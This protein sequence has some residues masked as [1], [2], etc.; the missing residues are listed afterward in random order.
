MVLQICLQ[1]EVCHPEERRGERGEER[2]GEE[3]RGN[4][5]SEG[6]K[7]Q[8][9]VG[10]ETKEWRLERMG[11]KRREKRRGG[12]SVEEKIREELPSSSLI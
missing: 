4:E 5:G 2:R 11:E 8:R 9:R 7:E 10:K 12:N 1:Q 3:E 6:G